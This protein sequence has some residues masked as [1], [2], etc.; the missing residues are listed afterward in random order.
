MAR[1]LVE[2]G[3]RFVTVNHAGWDT[4]QD[5][6]TR[7]RDGF[8][9]APQ[10]VGLG[11]SLDQAFTTLIVDLRDR[12]LLESTLVIVMGEFGRTPKLNAANGRDHWPRVFSVVLA[13]GGVAGGA[14]IGASDPMGESPSDQPV[15]P[16]D[17]AATLYH[18]LGIDP[19]RQL[20][21]PD[22]RPV[23]L[24]GDGTIIRDLVG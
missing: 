24:A 4:H 13:G 22:G 11:P 16:S 23:S 18:L 7:M 17:L 2:E 14:L 8:T 15:T 6:V 1:R 12:G 9:G 21:T 10:P 20:E 19:K 5:L 3:V